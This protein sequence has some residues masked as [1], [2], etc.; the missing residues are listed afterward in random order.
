MN[1]AR[2]ALKPWILVLSV[3]L[4]APL[5]AGGD[6]IDFASERWSRLDAQIVEHLGR[7][8]LEGTAILADV[9]FSDGVIEVD[10]AVSGARS[11]PGIIFRRQ[12]PTDLERFYVRPH[13]SNGA[14]SDALQYTPVI[15]GVAG[16]QLYSGDGFTGFATIPSGEWVH[17]RLEVKGTQAR[18]FVGDGDDPDLVIHELK[19]GISAGAIGLMGPK[20]GTA[21]FSNF[22]F[23]TGAALEFDPPPLVVAPIGVMTDWEL[24][25]PFEFSQIDIEKSPAE[26]GMKDLAWQAVKGEAT[27]LVDIARF[28]RWTPGEPDFVWARRT[29]HADGDETGKFEFGYSDYLSVFLNGRLLYTGNAAYRSRSPEFSGIVGLNDTLFLPL[30]KGDNE[31]LLLVGESFGGWGFMARDGNAIFVHDDLTR[32]WDLSKTLQFPESVIYDPR[33]D[34]LYVSN[35]FAG[36]S[37]FISKVKRD[38]TVEVL[39]WVKGVNGPAGLCLVGT[40]LFAVER[41][42]VAEIDVMSGEIVARHAVPEAG[43]PNDVTCNDSGVAF[44]SDS[45]KN[46]IYKVE[47]GEVTVWLESAEI[48]QPNGLLLD[49]DRLLVGNSGDGCLKAVSIADRAVET[50]ACLGSGSIIDGIRPDG[51]GSYIVSDYN[52]RVFRVTPSGEMT[53]LLNTSARGINAADLEYVPEHGLLV[54]PTLN[55]NQLIA[56][57]FNDA[58]TGR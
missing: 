46:L 30:K 24:S 50:I 2:F 42:A 14:F 54:I 6:R 15:N 5:A 37:G 36:G 51:R 26:Q 27:G 52:G 49:G 22:S 18:V 44:V 29:I 19:H 21:Y 58:A 45:R 13:R 40:R 20:D 32:S 57:L 48:S 47:A 9:A 1:I 25:R 4:T 8:C 34:V 23:E 11:Y 35:F 55:G 43:L 31:L 10:I 53:A 33:H 3:G 28:V 39:Q 56:Y 12:S 41:A 7:T 16:W 17:V 38:G